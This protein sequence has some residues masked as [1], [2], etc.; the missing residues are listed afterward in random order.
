[1]GTEGGD[2]VRRVVGGNILSVSK[3]DGG[4][5]VSSRLSTRRQRESIR[6]DQQVRGSVGTLFEQAGQRDKGLTFSEVDW[7]RL[8]SLYTVDG[9]GGET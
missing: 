2:G 9:P 3:I 1:M 6:E 7:R 5:L 8:C 4:R